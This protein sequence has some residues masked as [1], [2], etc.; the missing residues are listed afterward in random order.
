MGRVLEG[1]S[2]EGSARAIGELGFRLLGE[3]KASLAAHP[4]VLLQPLSGKS[5]NFGGQRSRFKSW[6]PH[7]PAL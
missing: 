1:L 3:L 7:F 2:P 5:M 4:A 6:L